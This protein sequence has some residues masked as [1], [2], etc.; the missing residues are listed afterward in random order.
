MMHAIA[1][2]TKGMRRGLSCFTAWGAL[3]WAA[4]LAGSAF[5]SPIFTNTATN[6]WVLDGTGQTVGSYSVL[7]QDW[8]VQASYTGFNIDID[9]DGGGST[10]LPDLG[11]AALVNRTANSDPALSPA[12]PSMS[13][14]GTGA[15]LFPSQGGQAPFKPGVL[16]DPPA[17]GTFDGTVQVRITP[18]APAQGGGTLEARYT[19]NP[20][21]PAVVTQGEVVFNLIQ[22]GTYVIEYYAF[23]NGHVSYWPAGSAPTISITI[24]AADPYRDTDGDGI[25][26]IV[27]DEYGLDPLVADHDLDSDGDG[28]TDFEELLRGSDPNDP[29]STPSDQDNDGWSDWD[30]VLRGTDDGDPNSYPTAN[31]L[32]EV[33]YIIDGNIYEDNAKTT[34]LVDNAEFSAMDVFWTPL[35][36]QDAPFGSTLPQIR[37]PAGQSIVLRTRHQF[38]NEPDPRVTRAWLDS[39]DDVLPS[40]FQAY[41]DANLLS[42]TDTTSWE[43]HYYSYLQDNLVQ[44]RNV[45]MT[46]ETGHAIALIDGLAAWLDDLE[47]EGAVLLG[48]P[49]SDQSKTAMQLVLDEMNPKLGSQ[50]DASEEIVRT[51]D[52][53]HADLVTVLAP[54]Q[55]ASGFA[56]TV[57][58]FY[59][60]LG[61]FAEPTTTRAAATLVQGDEGDDDLAA[62]YVSRL[63][64]LIPLADILLLPNSADLLDYAQDYDGDGELNVDE[65]LG[66]IEQTSSPAD[67]D[68]DDDGLL[69]A[70]DPCPRGALQECLIVEYQVADTD[71]DGLDDA[72][73]N[74]MHDANVDQA[75]ANGDA[76]GDACLRYANIRTPPSNLKIYTGMEVAFTSLDTEIASGSP[77]T[78]L[79][80][81]DGGAPNSNEADPGVVPF[82]TPGIFQVQFTA[83]DQ[84]STLP[85]D[86]RTITVLG[87]GP[88]PQVSLNGPFNVEE[89][90]D[91]AMTATASSQNGAITDYVWTYGDGDGEGGPAL[92]N[93]LHAYPADGAYQVQVEVTDAFLLTDTAT[94]QV[95]VTDS[96]PVA[97]FDWSPMSPVAPAQV[98][99]TDLSTAFDGIVGWS[100]DFDDNGA[101]SAAQSPQHVFAS[102]GIYNVSLTVEDGDGS[103]TPIVIPVEV[104]DP[105]AN[106]V[107]TLSFFGLL[108]LVGFLGGLAIVML[109]L[110]RGEEEG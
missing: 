80:D 27:E 99:F 52:D 68:T 8:T 102:P 31:R 73:D 72:V 76:I 2:G 105:N 41:L 65:L 28:W 101:T 84:G 45:D 58:G 6:V 16:I 5:A 54:A 70:Y 108:V 3:L 29:G 25:P 24:D 109:G 11:A 20:P 87:V 39:E 88:L 96:V 51:F 7:T 81:F 104:L 78:Y 55:P 74:C 100:W 15:P 4:L 90:V 47:G 50:L 95:T 34:P 63:L 44:P 110:E 14:M 98:N 21:G 1:T 42:W 66:R 53:L 46:P 69:D 64:T 91:L 75:D 67:D 9:G 106:P 86:L 107:P 82:Y 33:E 32:T 13:L 83:T 77:M 92:A 38:G 12:L 89:G 22:N 94:A 37:V 103:T 79:W 23:Q 10:S 30:E 71:G 36:K 57:D 93:V 17:G 59:A 18:I 43:A 26:D 40:G 60:N 19:I 61:S 97:S 62:R 49:T 35:A 85:A 56:A 48:N